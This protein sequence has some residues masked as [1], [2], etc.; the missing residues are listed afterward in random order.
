[1]DKEELRKQSSLGKDFLTYLCY[2]S[3]R[4]S[5]QVAPQGSD[6]QYYLWVDGKIALEDD[7]DPPPNTVSH[8]GND[9]T[10]HDL[11]QA[12]RSGKKV[13]EARFR[14]EQGANTWIFTLKAE[15]FE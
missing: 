2:K 13:K 10:D 9:F 8:S 4:E 1:M 14:I 3:D 15:R 12:L 11:K 5:G 7:K 6:G